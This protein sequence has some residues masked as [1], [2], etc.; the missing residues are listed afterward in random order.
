MFLYI[1]FYIFRMLGSCQIQQLLSYL[2]PFFQRRIGELLQQFFLFRAEFPCGNIEAVR[3]T[4]CAG[5]HLIASRELYGT[6]QSLIEKE[7]SRFGIAST[8]VDIGDLDAVKAAITPATRLIY[9]ET[10]SNPLVRVS[11]VPALAPPAG[12]WSWIGATR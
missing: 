6:T 11:D 4:L 7:L 12:G 9:T 10:A 8:L 1:L 3:F 5:D 2:R